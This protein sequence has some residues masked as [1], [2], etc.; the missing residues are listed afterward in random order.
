MYHI[1]QFA[2][3]RFARHANTYNIYSTGMTVSSKIPYQVAKCNSRGIS[4][5]YLVD[6]TRVPVM[7]DL[8]C[9]V[10]IIP[11]RFYNQ[12]LS[13]EEY[14]YIPTPTAVLVVTLKLGHCIFQF[15]SMLT[16]SKTSFIGAD[17]YIHAMKQIICFILIHR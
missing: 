17:V 13:L 1:V 3:F 14:V 8:G 11:K 2:E 4:M 5:S 7:M 6:G 12:H 16:Y 9:V 10:C 15:H